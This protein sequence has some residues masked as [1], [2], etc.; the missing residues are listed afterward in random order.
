[1]DANMT[2]EARKIAQE[3]SVWLSR[4]GWS[5]DGHDATYHDEDAVEWKVGD[6]G[7]TIERTVDI[8]IDAFAE[9]LEMRLSK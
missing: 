7:G 1:M 2:P 8:D 5:T 6:E 4:E 3:I 9:F